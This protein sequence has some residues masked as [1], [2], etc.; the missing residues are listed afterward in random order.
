M[1]NDEREAANCDGVVDGPRDVAA[2]VEVRR[3]VTHDKTQVGAPQEEGRF[4][5]GR[6]V[7][8]VVRHRAADDQRRTATGN[9]IAKEQEDCLCA[10]KW[11]T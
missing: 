5:C 2:L 6:P 9:G 7:T 11:G 4:T 1:P 8:G 3:H 10:E